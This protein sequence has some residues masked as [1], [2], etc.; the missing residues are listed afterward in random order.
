MAGLASIL[1][2]F[3][4][5]AVE[6]E[7]TIDVG[8][9]PEVVL[10]TN[11]IEDE[12]AVLNV[13]F[14]RAGVRYTNYSGKHEGNVYVSEDGASLTISTPLNMQTLAKLNPIFEKNSD[15]SAVGINSCAKTNPGSL[16]V[17]PICLG[18]DKSVDI[19]GYKVYCT[20]TITGSFKN[21]ELVMAT[22]LFE[23]AADTDTA[24]ET[25]GK[26]MSIGPYVIT[27]P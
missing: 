8:G 27:G 13:P 10:I 23:F 22:L 7:F 14:E 5:G 17:H 19:E 15:D 11:A 12:D 20:P 24:S 3:P 25:H 26:I 4:V 9:T 6:L 16:K 21:S 1:D 18:T 2:D